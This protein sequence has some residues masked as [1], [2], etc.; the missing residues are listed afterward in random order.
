MDVLIREARP[1]DAEGIV[2]VLNPIIET[3]KHT[4]FDTPFTAEAEG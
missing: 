1:E 3:G 4:I 2:R